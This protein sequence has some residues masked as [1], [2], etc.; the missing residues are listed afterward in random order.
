VKKRRLDLARAR[1]R[2]RRRLENR[3][4]DHTSTR[5]RELH[6]VA[7]ARSPP[8]SGAIPRAEVTHVDRFQ[9]SGPQPAAPG[10]IPPTLR[11]AAPAP[12]CTRCDLPGTT[13]VF[14]ARRFAR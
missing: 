2:A 10:F 8:E 12:R 14:G 5:S 4:A 13:L 9:Q 3:R 6:K 11:P 1:Y 7:L